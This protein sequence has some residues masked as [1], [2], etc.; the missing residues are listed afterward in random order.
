M[1]ILTEK[2]E[3]CQRNPIEMIVAD[4]DATQPYRV[5]SACAHRLRLLSLRPLEWFNLAALHGP[6]NFLLHDDFYWDNG[7]AQQADEEME[8]PEKYPAPTLRDIGD[9]VERLLDYAMTLYLLDA[10]TIAALTLCDSLAILRSL[11]RR[12]AVYPNI[13]IEAS[14]Y[15]ICAEALGASAEEWIRERWEK[16]KPE[17]FLSLAQATAKCL[18]LAEG[19][20]RITQVLDNETTLSRLQQYHE[21]RNTWCHAFAPFHSRRTLDWMELHPALINHEDWGRVAAQSHFSWPRAVKWLEQGRPLSHIALF[22]IY[23]CYRYDTAPLKTQ[24]PILEEAASV[25][26]MLQRLTNYYET[27]SVPRVQNLVRGIS[28]AMSKV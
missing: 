6:S 25:D 15:E 4:D 24:Q 5:C 26:E 1:G 21:G 23:A 20:Q 10:P 19:F 18:P 17:T 7:I 27:D 13:D 8:E 11:K 9:N 14:A 22:A 28:K 16:W 2:C 3:A 12:V